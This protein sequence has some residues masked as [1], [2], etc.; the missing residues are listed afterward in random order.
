[1]SQIIS[2][3]KCSARLRVDDDL[4]PDDRIECTRCGKRFL[5]PEEAAT[6]RARKVPTTGSWATFGCCL[7]LIFS[8]GGACIGWSNYKQRAREDLA[9]ADSLYAEGKKAEAV[10]KYKDRFSHLPD[11]RRAEVIKRIADH[12]ATA[13]DK[14]EARRWV[15]KGLDGKTEI[16]YETAAARDL[17]VQVKQERAEAEAKKK[18]AEAKKKAEREAKEQAQREMEEKAKRYGRSSDAL[19]AAQMLAKQQI[20]FPAE[21]R[22]HAPN[23]TTQNADG[24]WKVSGIV[25]S[26]N[27]FG[28]KVKYRFHTTVLRLENGDWREIEPVVFTDT[29]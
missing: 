22:F 21:A 14:A 2:C 15:E 8:C 28:V 23:E 16:A 11:D 17:L 18:E 26:K 1:M 7:L 9:A 25:T 20:T 13:G 4:D 12:E 19:L 5:P 6:H 10:A 29:D 24:S 3:P 27:A